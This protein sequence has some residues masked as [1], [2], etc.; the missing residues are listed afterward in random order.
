MVSGQLNFYLYQALLSLYAYS[1]V[2]ECSDLVRLARDS[3]LTPDD[4]QKL[5][6]RE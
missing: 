6:T 4:V 1:L 2:K 5:V 3:D